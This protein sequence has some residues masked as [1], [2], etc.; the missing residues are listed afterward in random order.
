[1]YRIPKVSI[2]RNYIQALQKCENY[3][4]GK[5]C[6]GSLVHIRTADGIFVFVYNRNL[7]QQKH[8]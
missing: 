7:Y 3:F 1:M 8:V 4:T 2:I 6:D 5:K